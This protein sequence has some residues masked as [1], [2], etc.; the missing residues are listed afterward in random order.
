[1]E[2]V[3]LIKAQLAA[4]MAN[5]KAI[6]AELDGISQFPEDDKAIG[7]RHEWLDATTAG[8]T[9]S[10]CKKCGV[11]LEYGEVTAENGSICSEKL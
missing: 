5:L 6:E 1:M 2:T 8:G 4:A 9:K 7:C 11:I 10:I 3:Q